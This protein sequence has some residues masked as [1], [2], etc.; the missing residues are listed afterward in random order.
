MRESPVI[1]SLR[2]ILVAVLPVTEL[3]MLHAAGYYCLVRGQ[4]LL[5]LNSESFDVSYIFFVN[6]HRR[7][8]F[9]NPLGP[10]LFFFNFST[11]FM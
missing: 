3:R 2:G 5:K 1:C 10:E 9:L 7:L 6:H 11:P 4:D 8:C